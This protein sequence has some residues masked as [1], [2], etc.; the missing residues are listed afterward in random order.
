MLIRSL[1]VLFATSG[2][3]SAACGPDEEV[4]VS[5]QI[6]ERETTLKVCIGAEM[7][8]YRYGPEG[9]PELSLAEPNASVGYTPWPGVGRAI[10]EDITFQNGAYSYTAY[11]GFDRQFGDETDEDVD[12]RRFGGVNVSRDGVILAE[13]ACIPRSVDFGWGQ[14]LWDA[15]IAAGLA[16]DQRS[17]TW[18]PTAE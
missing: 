13:L 14:A 2:M 18:Y 7:A 10:W 16:Y 11:G 12:N 8:T 5:C 4:F 1:A 3:A 15:K 6:A 9:Q 17:Q